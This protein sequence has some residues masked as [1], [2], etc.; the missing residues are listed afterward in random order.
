MARET[1]YVFRSVGSAAFSDVRAIRAIAGLGA[2]LILLALGAVGKVYLPPPADLAGLTVASGVSLVLG[3]VLV[4]RLA[5]SSARGCL[6]ITANGLAQSGR[7]PRTLHTK[8]IERVRDEGQ[9]LDTSHPAGSKC[10]RWRVVAESGPDWL[11]DD[12]LWRPTINTQTLS[13]R[14]AGSQDI[15]LTVGDALSYCGH[16]KHS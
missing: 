5:S 12:S 10:R 11:L 7:Q 2:L 13:Y 6:T 1:T 16:L 14:P 15:H 4:A 9:V 8:D 3:V